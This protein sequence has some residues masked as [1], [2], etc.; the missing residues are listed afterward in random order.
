[1]RGETDGRRP[2]QRGRA[3]SPTKKPRRG[4]SNS[5]HPTNTQCASAQTFF[6]VKYSSS[7][8]MIRNTDTFIPS[9]LRRMTDWSAAAGPIQN[10]P[11]SGRGAAGTIG[12]NAVLHLR[13]ASEPAASAGSR[14]DR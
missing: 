11:M 2:R 4:F 10:A 1:M 7:V 5:R 12:M 3:T 6:L 13:R 8:R 9:S 14:N